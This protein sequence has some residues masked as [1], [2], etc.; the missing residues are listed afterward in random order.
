MIHHYYIHLTGIMRV[1]M[2]DNSEDAQHP[3]H[4]LPHREVWTDEQ[5]PL[6]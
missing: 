6:R 3:Q 1:W 2:V 5:G 4:L